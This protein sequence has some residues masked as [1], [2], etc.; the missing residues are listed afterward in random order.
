MINN[1]TD[2]STSKK[3]I[4]KNKKKLE[5]KKTQSFR[6]KK[7]FFDYFILDS[8]EAGIELLGSEVKAIREGRINLKDSFIKIIRGEAFVFGM[9]ISHL[10]TTNSRFRPEEL[11]SRKLLLHKKQIVKF[12]EKCDKEG[13]TIMATSLYFNK[14]NIVKLQVALAKGKKNYDKRAVLKEKS[15]QK[16]IKNQLKNY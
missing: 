4:K 13:L 3:N 15:I 6:N 12:K 9:H 16:D 1:I 8:L 5:Q 11:R 14:K 10:E 7:A 2:N